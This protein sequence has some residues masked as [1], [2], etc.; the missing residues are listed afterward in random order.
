MEFLAS[1]P[2]LGGFLAV[3]LPFLIVLGVVVFVH[4]YGHYIVG[5]W[6]GIHA[7][8]FSIG[9]G[10]PLKK[11][12]DKRGTVW[13]I[14]LLPLGGY[15]KFL[16]DENASSFGSSDALENMGATE[17]SRSFPGA[18]VWRRA[19]TVAAGPVFNFILSIVMFAG[20]IMW[21][22][23]ATE[24]PVVAEVLVPLS[25]EQ[26]LREGDEILAVNGTEV[27]SYVEVYS[28]LEE[29]QSSPNL[30][31]TVRRDGQVVNVTA[32]YL[33]PPLVA[34][35]TPFSPASDAGLFPDDLILELGGTPL[36]SFEDLREVVLSSEGVDLPMVILR[37]GERIDLSIKPEITETPRPDG[38]G[39]EKRVM[40]GVSGSLAFHPQ[41]E[42]PGLVTST[43]EGAERVW[44]VYHLCL[45]V[46]T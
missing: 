20:L 43:V 42:V 1:I 8:T 28:E 15:V 14:A 37:D 13:Q 45:C 9:Y 10:R 23:K 18:A 36:A 46:A 35:V 25:D 6:C 39:W 24:P 31:L 7:E 27:A 40:I 16:G 12:T 5:R 34:G 41:T 32:P 3:V 29:A 22:G 38:E 11:W 2:L 33:L 21:Q 30:E 26:D 17:R 19:L 4:E 44:R